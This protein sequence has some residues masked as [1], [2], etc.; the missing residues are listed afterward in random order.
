MAEVE[1]EGGPRFD[2]VVALGGGEPD[3]GSAWRSYLVE[4]SIPH[5]ARA[6]M[7]EGRVVVRSGAGEVVVPLG[8]EVWDFT[9]PDFLSFLPEMNCYGLP[10]NERDF[11]R[12]AH[13]HRTVLN[14]V[15]YSQRGTISDGC[16]PGWDG[17]ELDWSAWDERFGPLLDG[18]AFADLPRKGVP[19][20]V[21]YLPVHENWPTPMEGNY[22]GDYW[23]DRAFPESY[24]RA[25]VK[26]TRGMAEHFEAKGWTE[27][28][29][30]GF[31]NNKHDFKNNGWS[32]GS[33]PWLLDEPA[34][35]QDFWALRYYGAAFH[36]GVRAAGG[37][38]R[39][40][41]RADISRPEWQ[42]DSLDGLLD[43]S[44][45]A[46]SLRQY[47][48]IVFDRKEREGQIVLEYGSASE[49]GGS[50]AQGAAWCVDAWA[51][52]CDG[53]V[54]WQTV[55][56]AGSWEEADRL[57][58]LYPAPPWAKEKNTVVPS[59]RLKAFRRGQQDV[60]YLTLWSRVSGE[61]RWAVGEAVRGSLGM[62]GERKGT[63]FAGEDAGVITYGDLGPADLWKVRTR[64]GKA[65]SEAR[66]AAAR[67]LE[68]LATPPRDP[69]RLDEREVGK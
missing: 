19:L 56:T 51:I 49:I 58:L 15:P 11:Y 24:R 17:K 3:T 59:I 62:R 39:M 25:F 8:L 9:L 26:V 23:A 54:P 1:T 42:R 4:F 13:E 27:P 41:Y 18:S 47:P 34:S 10:D 35:F 37:R 6:G 44:V 52:G 66:P 46:S 29:F 67:R 40:L 61:P 31:L 68:E 20:E 14:R 65:L 53:V 16:A 48:R 63:G 32:R 36:E 5:E 7:R 64:V 38:A 30:H 57:A 69:G 50:N 43:Y 28:R 12:L 45:T 22:N 2:P 33:S 55:G 21:F 60:E